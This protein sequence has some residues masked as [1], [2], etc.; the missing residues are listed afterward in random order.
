M[1]DVDGRAVDAAVVPTV[2]SRPLAGERIVAIVAAARARPDVLVVEPAAGAHRVLRQELGLRAKPCADD[3]AP[4]DRVVVRD[5]A[6]A[7]VRAVDGCLG[8][9]AVVVAHARRPSELLAGLNGRRR[10][11]QRRRWL[12]G[13][14]QGRRPERRRWFRRWRQG[15]RQRGWLGRRPRRWGRRRDCRRCPRRGLQ[16]RRRRGW[17]QRRWRR[18]R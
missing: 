3:R 9:D 16:R 2:G 17:W 5:G 15:R 13:R 12:R 10:R 7:G 11:R 18:R 1:R 14:H 6:G 8:A 4:L